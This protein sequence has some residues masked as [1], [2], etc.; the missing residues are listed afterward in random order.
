M[1]ISV[2]EIE[3]LL[4]LRDE[5]T[6]SLK[7]A[8]TQLAKTGQDIQR[9]GSQVQAAGG[10]MLPLSAA[11]AGVGAAVLKLGKDFETSLTRIQTLSGE[12]SASVAEMKKS[13][14][15][16]APAVGIGPVALSEALRVITSTGI[17]GAEALDILQASAKSS[18]VGMGDAKDVARALT[19]AISAYGKENLDAA[20]A[21]EVLFK[22]VREGGAE[23]DEV[24]NALGRVVGITAQVGV[25]FQ[26]TGAFIATFTRLGVN[27]EEAVTALRGV[28]TT[29]IKPS[30][31]AKKAL[32]G[33]GSSVEALRES[34]QKK[35]L[36]AALIDLVQSTNGNADAMAAIVPN[37]RALAGILGT[38]GSQAEAMTEIVRRLTM[39]S[40]DLGDAF[41]RTGETL[42]Q[43]FN[44]Q[45]AKMQVIAIQAFDT[46]RATFQRAAVAIDPLIDAIGSVVTAMAKWPESTKLVALGIAAIV[47]VAAPLLV[48]LGSMIRL[49]GFS[50][51]GFAMLGTALSSAARAFTATTVAAEATSAATAVNAAAQ[52][53]S[54]AKVASSL[55]FAA[56]EQLAFNFAMQEGAQI[57]LPFSGALNQTAAA[58]S[59]TGASLAVAG[60]W[61]AKNIPTFVAMAEAV[62][63]LALALGVAMLGAVTNLVRAFPILA[64]TVGAVRTAFLSLW[65]ALGPI[66]VA[67]LAIW[68]AWKVGNI[69]AVKNSIAEWGLSADNLTAKLFRLVAG[70]QQLTPEQ[71]KAAV[72][73][74]AAAKSASDAAANFDAAAMK[75]KMAADQL[76]D[77][78]D[79]LSGATAAKDL[80]RIA[81]AVRDLGDAGEL[82]PAAMRRLADE[83]KNMQAAGSDL[84]AWA[85]RVVAVYGDM[86]DK[87]GSLATS[88]GSLS[89]RLAAAQKEMAKFSA[90]QR[91]NI[92]AGDAMHIS[93]DD[94]TKSLNVTFPT[95]KASGEAV[96]LFVDQLH[97]GSSA[98]RQAAKDFSEI[99]GATAKKDASDL[100]KQLG[101]GQLQLAKLTEDAQRKVAQTLLEGSLAWHAAGESVSDSVKTQIDAVGKLRVIPD[102]MKAALVFGADEQA[103]ISK[104]AAEKS[105]AGQKVVNDRVLEN[106]KASSAAYKASF[107]LRDQLE[108]QSLQ[109]TLSRIKEEFDERRRALNANNAFYQDAIDAIAEEERQTIAVTT[110]EWM[111]GQAQTR[112]QLQQTADHAREQFENIRNSNKFTTEEIQAA[113]ERWYE[114]DQ[115]ARGAW[116]GGWDE[117]LGRIADAFQQLAQIAGK[118]LNAIVRDIGVFVASLKLGADSAK[119]FKKG[120]KEIGDGQT[121]AGLVD[122]A[123]GII[124]IASAFMQATEHGNTFTKTLKGAALG[125]KIGSEFGPIGTAV[126]ASIGAAAGFLRGIFGVSDVEKEGRQ[127]AKDFREGLKKG[128]SEAQQDELRA[129]IKIG[130]DP[131]QTATVIAIRDAYKAL[132]RNASE[133]DDIVRRLWEAEKQGG[134]AVQKV[135]DEVNDAFREQAKLAADAKEFADTLPGVL[136]AVA[137]S[138]ELVSAKFQGIIDKMKEAGQFT[139]ELRAF[140]SGQ[141]QVG[142]GG[143]TGF[144]QV[145]AD[146]IATLKDKEQELGDLRKQLNDANADSQDDIRQKIA[147]VTAEI[148]T[149]QKVLK[150]AGISS[151]QSAEALGASLFG[152]FAEMQRQGKSVTEALAAVQP[153]VLAM[154]AQLERSGMSGGA[155]FNELRRYVALMTDEIGGPAVKAILSLNDAFVG[156]HNSGLLTQSTFAGL[157]S[158][159]T[160]TFNELVKQGKDG[161]A[162]L[163]LI[164]PTL[165]TIWEL[166]QDFGY[167]VDAAT[168]HLLDQ[169]V[170]AGLVGDKHRDANEK[171]AKGIE[172]LVTLMEAFV[173]SLGIDVPDAAQVAVGAIDGISHALDDSVESVAELTSRLKGMRDVSDYG[174]VSGPS[175]GSTLTQADID[176]FL[177]RNPNDAN[178]IRQAFSNVTDPGGLLANYHQGGMLWKRAHQGWMVGSKVAHDEVPIMAQ[179]GEAILSRRGVQAAGGPTAIAS[180][181]TGGRGSSSNINISGVQISVSGV[182]KNPEQIA[183]ELLPA[184]ITELRRNAA[185]TRSEM[186]TMFEKR[187]AS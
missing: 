91:E 172:R 158:Q 169:G 141:A 70:I 178:R 27:A 80:D 145:G 103:R 59:A 161:D 167:A 60:G 100:A 85:K 143:V 108:G 131:N 168:Q 182:D 47:A 94:I 31:E 185:G 179:A 148:Q 164:Q 76:A 129:N 39:V 184:F 46:F 111:Y 160:H 28:M 17:H 123:D 92:K 15:D 14:L 78:K 7:L 81:Q 41:T 138:G 19:A 35:G 71:A 95:L 21:A 159:V 24:A 58:A 72:A 109:R 170:A 181:N 48:A 84:P 52:V 53:A 117:A 36:T 156:L 8:S 54:A 121:K 89:D 40:D 63:S 16:L 127:A 183:R 18:A 5:L 144:L 62:K 50:V 155:A 104:E 106:I 122:L 22:T 66:A 99:S 110:R 163:R 38:A 12:T 55:K 114:A 4:R 128:L 132:G 187:K 174:G 150:V 133:A 96:Q 119:D 118:T 113:W 173:R 130:A 149:Q 73:A 43:K 135:I 157:S 33:M 101:T 29:V 56:G 74:N 126:G 176:D 79:R 120:V 171:I 153:G 10:A 32:T 23:A 13:V 51:E 75:A 116:A 136:D 186:E 177:A 112:K 69:G 146:A 83:L 97:A 6:P 45:L 166:Q 137:K 25:S 26:E 139:D 115:R 162:A 67:L 107:A 3:A 140:I 180:L 65:S 87:S 147:K 90:S 37:V 68:A 49:V 61:A 105:A 124:G 57:L 88:T 64:T 165:Q 86:A 20:T 42:D 125:A 9:F 134:K 154:Q 93:V 152:A 175:T 142:A 1:A 98:A 34:I 102:L 2:G 77:M 82:T 11:V 151:Q 30:E 44:V